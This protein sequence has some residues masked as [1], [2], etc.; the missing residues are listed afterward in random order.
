MEPF[1]QF[2]PD[3]EYVYNPIDEPMVFAPHDV[4]SKAVSDCPIPEHD[5]TSDPWEI[6]T[7]SPGHVYFNNV[8]TQ[9]TW[10]IATRS[11][12][13]G[14]PSRSG[15]SSLPLQNTTAD[16]MLEQLLFPQDIAHTRNICELPEAGDTHG[17]FLSPGSAWHTNTLVPI[18]SRTKVS[19]N[20]DLLMPATDYTSEMTWFY[21]PY[22]ESEDMPWDEKQNRLYW[23]GSS[24]DGFFTDDSWRTSHR[25]RFVRDLNNQSKPIPLLRKNE[26]S[27]SWEPYASRMKALSEYIHVG[28]PDA[29]HCSPEE[30]DRMRDPAAGLAFTAHEGMP[31]SYGSKFVLDIDGSSYTERFQR[32]LHSRGAVFKMTIFQEWHDDFLA[33]WVHYVPVTLGMRELPETLRFFVETAAGQEIGRAIAAEGRAWARR[34]WRP[35]DM[36][37]A[38]FRILLEYAR[39]WGPERDRTGECPRDRRG[40]G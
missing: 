37:I 4:L 35:V 33:P 36:K 5:N 1:L 17:I 7:K 9:R 34:T 29:S 30:C 22:N 27:G 26:E 12:P 38:L 15:R 20:Q 23:T 25:F 39:L 40:G 16:E 8:A 10:E 14:S 32:L 13:P 28:F 6:S 3:M 19:T 18:F 21:K 11:C 2:L 24:S 31:A